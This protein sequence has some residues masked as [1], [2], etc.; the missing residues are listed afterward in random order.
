MTQIRWKIVYT[1]SQYLRMAESTKE[2]PYL[3][4]LEGIDRILFPDGKITNML[5]NG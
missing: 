4:V 2:F 1:V 5:C 3:M